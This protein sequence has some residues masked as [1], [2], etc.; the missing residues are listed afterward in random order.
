MDLINTLN[1]SKYFSGLIMVLLN[2]GSKYV[3]L[4][5]SEAQDFFL[6]H[7]II[8]KALVFTIFF[9][10]TKDIVVSLISTLVFLLLVCFILHEES[11]LCF[12]S[13]QMKKFCKKR[14]QK[15]TKEEYE[16]AMKIVKAYRN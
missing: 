9:I 5:I 2:L 11:H 12:F 14:K 4:E 6:S 16:N 7:P 3:S 13:T 1:N 10:A 8:R 15:V